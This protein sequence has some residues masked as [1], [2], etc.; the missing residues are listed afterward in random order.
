MTWPLF[1][2]QMAGT[3]G[4]GKSTLAHLL[5]QRTGAAAIDYDVVKSAALDAGAAWDLAG[6]VGYGASRAIAAT[7][8]RQGRSVI[9]DSPCRFQMIV[10]EGTAIARA[11]GAAYAFVECVLGDEPELRRRMQ[12]RPRQRSQRLGLRPAAAGRARRRAGRRERGDPCAR[13]RA[14]ARPVAARRHRSA[15]RALPGAGA[16]LP[17]RNLSRSWQSAR[18]TE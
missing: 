9:L 5:G 17:G 18:L 3:S 7:L 11:S 16:A 15:D 12:A 13:Q 2:L 1:L 8:L 14:A 10:D 6:R 4:A